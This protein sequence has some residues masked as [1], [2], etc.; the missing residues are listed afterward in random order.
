M[1]AVTPARVKLVDVANP[2]TQ[3]PSDV[4]RHA[5]QH[6]QVGQDLDPVGRLEL[7][8]DQRR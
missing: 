3:C 4:S 5:A 8:I 6:E 7:V 2:A 1:L